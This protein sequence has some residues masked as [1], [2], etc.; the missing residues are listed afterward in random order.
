[1]PGVQTSQQDVGW[2]R[3][4]KR[5]V[6]TRTRKEQVGENMRTEKEI[7]D[8]IVAIEE[9]A[10]PFIEDHYDDIVRLMRSQIKGLKFA[11][12]EEYSIAEGK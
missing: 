11:L 8:R 9:E 3:R 6:E 7:R 1:M 5:N 10:K 12:G 4:C 2:R